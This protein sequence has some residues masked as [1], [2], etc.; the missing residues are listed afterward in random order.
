M[1]VGRSV[2]KKEGMLTK[3]AILPNEGPYKYEET[4]QEFVRNKSIWKFAYHPDSSLRSAV[5]RAL[6]AVLDK[7]PGM[8]QCPI[9]GDLCQPLRRMGRNVTRPYID[10]HDFQGTC[11]FAD[12]MR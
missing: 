10:G 3:L 9:A 6:L 4:Y 12:R 1:C 2:I 5:Y 8:L 11:H 7:H